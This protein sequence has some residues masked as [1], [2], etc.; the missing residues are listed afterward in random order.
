VLWK[1]YEQVFPG[2]GQETCEMTVVQVK[3]RDEESLR[4]VRTGTRETIEHLI[5]KEKS[6]LPSLIKH[7]EEP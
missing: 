5:S 4:D 7:L 1:C 2:L 6:G 3:V